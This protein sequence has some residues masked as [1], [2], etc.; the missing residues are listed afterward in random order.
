ML[1]KKSVDDINVKGKRVLVRCDF[2]VPL[3]DGKITDENRLVAALPTIK[4]LVADGGKIILCSHLG[5]PKG[6]PKPE[7]SLAPVAKRLTELLGQEVKFVPSP[8]V[9]D[10]TVIPVIVQK[11]LRTVM[12]SARNLLLF[13]MY[14]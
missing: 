4:K 13:A 3:Q 5:K 14:L 1:N 6:E 10:D 11:R 7:L 2:N 8:V 9:V 12:N